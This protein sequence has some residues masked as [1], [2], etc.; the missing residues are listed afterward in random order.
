MSKGGEKSCGEGR[1]LVPEI[2]SPLHQVS[3]AKMKAF[4]VIA[5][6]ARAFG[7]CKNIPVSCEIDSMAGIGAI[8]FNCEEISIDGNLEKQQKAWFIYFLQ[9]CD[10]FY[11]STEPSAPG[12]IQFIFHLW[13]ERKE[14]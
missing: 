7:E 2:K 12:G 13:D 14:P 6:R 5:D 10:Y 4:Q 9:V 11:A 3:P 1:P 8:R